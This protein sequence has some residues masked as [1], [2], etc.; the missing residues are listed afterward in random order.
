MGQ[1]TQD[2]AE[3]V[4]ENAHWADPSTLE[5]LRFIIEQVPA[6]LL[7]LITLRP[8][9]S[10]P[11]QTGAHCLTITLD[12]LDNQE[13]TR[14]VEEVAGGGG[15]ARKPGAQRRACLSFQAR[16]DPGCGV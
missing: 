14:L 7:T 11:W 3:L 16:A 12:H 1:H 10:V 13:T 15:A 6:A 2:A 8:G 9:F 4:V 5:A